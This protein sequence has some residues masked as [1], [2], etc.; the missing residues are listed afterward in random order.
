MNHTENH[1]IVQD[2][3][4]YCGRS[5]A[6]GAGFG[7]F[8]NRIPVDDGWGCAEC[9]GF[10]CDECGQKIYLDCELRV[11]HVDSDGNWQY[12]NYHEECYDAS[13]HG[14]LRNYNEDKE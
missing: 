4:V 12:G 11:D 3:C 13:R 9:S 8:V 14:I 10:E 1:I 5:T 2:P 7:L 6:F